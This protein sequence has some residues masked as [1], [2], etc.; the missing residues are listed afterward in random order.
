[1]DHALFLFSEHFLPWEETYFQEERGSWTNL[2]SYPESLHPFSLSCLSL[3]FF[4]NRMKT[5]VAYFQLIFG[6]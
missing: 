3:F 2:S 5:V 6:Q 4:S 1:M